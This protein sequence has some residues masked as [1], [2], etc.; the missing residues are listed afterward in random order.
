MSVAIIAVA[1][2]LVLGISTLH[3]WAF[4]RK[5]RPRRGPYLLI[6]VFLLIGTLFIPLDDGGGHLKTI[7]LWVPYCLLAIPEFFRADNRKFDIDSAVI[8]L[9]LIHHLTC[10][11]LA[12]LA[13]HKCRFTVK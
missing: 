6:L 10:V 9:L 1:V 12:S 7:R 2:V 4:L 13:V 11:L 3:V 5:P 8:G